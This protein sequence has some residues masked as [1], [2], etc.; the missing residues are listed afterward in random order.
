MRVFQLEGGW[1]ADHL[2]M[3]ERPKP[4]P[5][6]GQVLLRMCAASLNYRDTVVLQRGYGAQTGQLPLVPVSDGVGEVVAL[7]PG[8]ARV[9]VGDRVCPMFNPSWIGGRPTAARLSLTLGG[10]IDGVMQEYLCIDAESVALAP[11]HLSDIEAAT[12]PCAALTAWSAL[13]TEGRI[14]PG[15]RVLIQGTGGVSLFALQF[16]KMLGAFTIVTSSSNQKLERARALG[17][18]AILSYRETPEWGRSVREIAGGEGVD[19][20]V[21]VGGQQTL[22]QSLRAIRAGGT[23]SMIGV[24]SGP[25]MEARLGLVVTRQVRLQG[26][27]VGSRDGFEAMARAISQHKLHPVVDRIFPFEELP[28]ALSYLTSGAHFG[29]IC[30]NHG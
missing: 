14:E 21:E 7:G 17:A 19:H 25:S 13:V 3:A 26:I 15:D 12:L 8:V 28:Q 6:P 24:L 27:T 30:I 5:G 23:I 16:A 29:K 18:D 20:I 2:V 22:P 1:S 10:P 11:A 4:E 9:K